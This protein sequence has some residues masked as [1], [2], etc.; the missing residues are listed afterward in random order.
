[1]GILSPTRAD[2]K[3][4]LTHT[5]DGASIDLQ[6]T[7]GYDLTK[8]W[9]T[10]DGATAYAYSRD[11]LVEMMRHVEGPHLP[12]L[13]WVDTVETSK[14][15]WRIFRMPY[16]EPLAAKHKEAWA[17]YKAIRGVY[18]TAERDALAAA[19]QRKRETG[20]PVY[21]S[22]SDIFNPFFARLESVLS[23]EFFEDMEC[24]YSWCGSYGDDVRMSTL[25]S[26]FRVRGRR[27]I[28]S[29]PFFK[30]DRRSCYV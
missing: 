12:N 29:T 5:I 10:R 4:W 22:C 17:D 26:G 9:I 25:R 15:D 19:K 7:G 27:L 18:E 14:Y 23:S 24:L 1:M 13:Q 16:A 30:A 6:F 2:K 28:V 11:D 21:F 8:W 3:R 20:R